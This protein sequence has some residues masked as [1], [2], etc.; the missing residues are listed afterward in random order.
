MQGGRVPC[1]AQVRGVLRQ[2]RS[3]SAAYFVTTAARE[4][5]ST[6]GRYAL[7]VMLQVDTG[8]LLSP[9]YLRVDAPP[10]HLAARV[11]HARLHQQVAI[12]HALQLLPQLQHLRQRVR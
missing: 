1:T 10:T 8:P 9:G 12:A 4:R 2:L 3:R 6:V 11:G 5:C 7:S